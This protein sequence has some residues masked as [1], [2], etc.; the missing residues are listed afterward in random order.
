VTPANLKR[1]VALSWITAAVAVFAAGNYGFDF[2][3]WT[4]HWWADTAWTTTSLI[5]GL[6]CFF[7][8]ERLTGH[9]KTAWNLWG[10]GCFSWFGGMIMWD[11]LELILGVM[12]PFPAPSDFGFIALAPFFIAGM[13]YYRSAIPT[14]PITLTQIGNLGVIFCAIL[15]SEQIILFQSIQK[16]TE[17]WW[18]LSTALSYPILYMSAFFFGLI[19]LWLYVWGHERRILLFITVGIAVHGFVD[20][21]YAYSLLGKTYETGSYLD[22]YWIIGFAFIYWAALEQD[23]LS[24]DTE[25]RAGLRDT[26]GEHLREWEF[27]I[28][29]IAIFGVLL[30]AFLFR[31]ELDTRILELIFPVSVVLVVFL[32]L[33]GWWGQQLEKQSHQERL[34]ALDALRESQEQFRQAQKMEAMGRLSGG[35]AHDFNNLLTA[36][37]GYG[38]ILTERLGPR[39]PLIPYVSGIL[40]AAEGGASLTNQLLLFSRRKVL[41]LVVMNLNEVLLQLRD[42]LQRIIGEDIRLVT[43]PDPALGYIKADRG[44]MEQVIMNLAVNARDAM[45]QGGEIR[46][47]TRNVVLNE[48]D[49]SRYIDLKSG[50]YVLLSVSD[51]GTG[52][53]QETQSHI[54]EPFFTTKDATKGTGLGLSTIYAIVTQSDGHIEVISEPGQGATFKI[55]L[56]R[57]ERPVEDPKPQE[58]SSPPASGLE[59]ILVVEDDPM[60][61]ELF[62]ET[63]RSRG[64]RVLEASQG[65]EALTRYGASSDPIDLLITDVVM[66]QMNGPMLVQQLIPHRPLMKVLFISGYTGEVADHLKILESEIPFLQKPFTPSS[67]SSKIREV[68]DTPQKRSIRNP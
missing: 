15:I 52:M 5:V 3:T 14:F 2:A 61:R 33:K 22:V 26:T 57:V 39:H 63:L 37:Q 42:M 28:P 8:A 32:A 55:Y 30:T 35:I 19:C 43:A 49:V 54:F 60:L 34:Q 25:D 4:I 50:V 36:I 59:T 18:Y 10:I 46:I 56:P 12:T 38:A 31:E 29:A 45:T 1:V 65:Q 13:F 66:P 27:L 51:T 17:S 64:Y 7:T 16:N 23:I 11:Y 41:N 53:D 44:Q 40:R 24:D 68:L 62:G 20:T 9:H 6:R 21:L 58:V 67:L 48:A 47:E